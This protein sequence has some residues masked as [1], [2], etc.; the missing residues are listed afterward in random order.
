ME[1]ALKPASRGQ[2]P[3]RQLGV[4]GALGRPDEHLSREA[5]C[6]SGCC[7]RVVDEL[8]IDPPDVIDH[9]APPSNAATST[10]AECAVLMYRGQ[11]AV[12]VAVTPPVPSATDWDVLSVTGRARRFRRGVD[13]Q[14]APAQDEPDA[15]HRFRAGVVEPVR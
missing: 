7:R 5:M 10:V 4:N 3:D 9:A 13:V 6:G 1:M 8:P 2:C 11:G 14:R 12:R 15:V